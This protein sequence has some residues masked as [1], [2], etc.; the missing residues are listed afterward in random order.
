MSNN[1]RKTQNILQSALKNIRVGGNLSIGTIIQTINNQDSDQRNKKIKTSRKSLL[2]TMK[3]HIF[4]VREQAIY[5][6]T[7]IKLNFEIQSWQISP[8]WKNRTPVFFRQEDTEL[9]K[10][11]VENIF[12]QPN[13]GGKLLILGSPGAGKTILLHELTMKLVHRAEISEDYP[14]PVI[15]SLST[16]T[17]SNQSLFDWVLA[18]LKDKYGI[19]IEVAKHWVELKEVILLLDGLDEV[20]PEFTDKCIQLINKFINEYCPP[21]VVVCSRKDEYEASHERLCLNSCILLCSLSEL[22]IRQYLESLQLSYKWDYLQSSP[23]LMSLCKT[24]LMLHFFALVKEGAIDYSCNE[25]IPQKNSLIKSYL[26]EMLIYPMGENISFLKETYRDSKQALSVL[27]WLASVLKFYEQTEF[28]VDDL[29]PKHLSVRYKFIYFLIVENVVLLAWILTLGV[30]LGLVIGISSWILSGF[31]YKSSFN[32]SFKV[33]RDI[34]FL[35][36][37]EWSWIRFKKSIWLALTTFIIVGGIAWIISK[38]MP[39]GLAGG[40]IFGLSVIVIVSL[41]GSDIPIPKST[42]QGLKNTAVSAIIFPFFL[43]LSAGLVFS[44]INNTDV[45][46][47]LGVLGGFLTPGAAVIQHFTVRLLLSLS[48]SLPFNYK[49]FLEYA[50]QKRILQRVGGRYRFIH[51]Y[52]RDYFADNRKECSSLLDRNS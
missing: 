26:Q 1:D 10:N 33:I 8:V 28:S 49:K 18:E 52:L 31:V 11:S 21:S 32:I 36:K 50:T 5:G 44:F 17:R 25:V 38:N 4:N 34:Q 16:W 51:I 43:G 41:I 12:D 42:N 19:A 27:S 29:Q 15:L 48:E 7:L 13:V 35:K 22:E 37:F 39:N 23:S 20:N 6:N 45:G 9:V 40:T 14:I 24:P 30:N 2:K 46:V 3:E 47:R